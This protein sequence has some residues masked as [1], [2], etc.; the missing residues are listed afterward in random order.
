MSEYLLALSE[1]FDRVDDDAAAWEPSLPFSSWY[2]ALK[3][4]RQSVWPAVERHR[5]AFLAAL[6]E[7]Q[8]HEA[9]WAWVHEHR[10]R[11][12]AALE[13]RHAAVMARLRFDADGNIITDPDAHGAG[14]RA[15]DR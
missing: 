8:R 2:W 13:A 4:E 15:G 11:D 14:E 1:Q 5:Q 12:V 10:G 7:A 3:R 6:R 9:D